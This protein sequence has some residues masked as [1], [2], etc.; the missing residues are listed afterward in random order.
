MRQMKT[1]FLYPGMR[2]SQTTPVGVVWLWEGGRRRPRRPSRC[3]ASAP[4]AVLIAPPLAL[5]SKGVPDAPQPT[6]VPEVVLD[7][8]LFRFPEGCWK[9]LVLSPL[10]VGCRTHLD[11][12]LLPGGSWT[13]GYRTGGCQMLLNPSL[14]PRGCQVRPNPSQFPGG[15]WIHSNPLLLAGGCQMHSD[16]SLP[17]RR[18]HRY[19]GCLRYR[20]E[21]PAPDA[22]PQPP[23]ADA[24]PQPPA[25]DAWPEH[26]PPDSD[27]RAACTRA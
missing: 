22:W 10:P 3:P 2:D 14:L 26:R 18:W 20:S 8:N 13:G 21:P 15:Y 9:H 11:P 25:T 12:S 23:A 27:T 17:P 5:V 6:S 24:R 19:P 1:N 7:P 16:S 4:R